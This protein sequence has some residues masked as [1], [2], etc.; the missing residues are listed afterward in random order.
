MGFIVRDRE[1]FV[2]TARSRTKLE[3][4]GPVA[5]EAFV[6]FYEIE[7]SKDLGLRKIFLEG[8]TLQVV[9]AIMARIG[10]GMVILLITYAKC[11]IVC[12]LDRLVMLVEW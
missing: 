7:F 1:G 10:A 5:T 6:A 2:L 3:N 11:L 8:D 12:N 4:L 9:N